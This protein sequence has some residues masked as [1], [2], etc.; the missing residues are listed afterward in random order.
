M[1]EKEHF[2]E[3]MLRQEMPFRTLCAKYGI[4]EKTGYKWR[5]RYLEEGYAG[6]TEASRAPK[7][8]PNSL[9][10]DTVIAL[11]SLKQ[12]HPYWG[13]KKIL[14]L[15]AKTHKGCSLPSLSSVNR[16][17]RKAGLVRA[18]RVRRVSPESDRLHVR[19][20]PKECNDVWAIDFKG[21]WRSDGEM[22]EP[23]TV[24][25]LFSR[26]VLCAKLM[27]SRT[28]GAVRA[29]MED[30]FRKYGL[31]K[32]IRSDNGSPFASPNGI[33]SLTQLSAWWI[34]LGIIPSRTQKG[35][36]GQNGSLERFHADMAR[37]VE[38][39][40]SGGKA[41]NQAVIDDWLVEYNTVR[42]NEAIGMR[43]PD[44]VYTPSPRKYTG[45]YDLLEYPPGYL[46]RKVFSGGQVAVN[47]VRV[48]VGVS[49]KGFTLGLLP[50]ED[51]KYDA[52]LA[53][54]LLGTIDTASACFVPLET[55]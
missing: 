7:G 40:V 48:S 28:S 15:Y 47:G 33:L 10:E 37:E 55:L 16:V 32:A 43:V 31:P 38:G 5:R 4:S 6:L 44:D 17:L 29:V 30:L 42:P 18:R 11:I 20:E 41:A 13:G 8:S 53:D 54:F 39:K 35:H 46:P 19:I 2:I 36:P 52:Y 26:K 12:A 14:A 45:D 50:R 25:D 49:L 22:C 1:Q 9:D 21:W 27:D 24:R 23:F 3:E 34:S 51:G